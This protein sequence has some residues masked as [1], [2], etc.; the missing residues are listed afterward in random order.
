MR[1]T[2][3]ARA[4]YTHLHTLGTCAL[5]THTLVLGCF[6]SAQPTHALQHSLAHARLAL[7]HM[8]W[9]HTAEL[10]R[11]TRADVNKYKQLHS[12]QR[13]TIGIQH[14]SR[15]ADSPD[16]VSC[17]R[18]PSHTHCVC[19]LS[20][21]CRTWRSAPERWGGGTGQCCAAAHTTHNHLML[22]LDGSNCWRTRQ[23]AGTLSPQAMCNTAGGCSNAW[24]CWRGCSVSGSCVSVLSRLWSWLAALVLPC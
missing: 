24:K 8:A 3:A 9:L 21:A 13:H 11:C 14:A 15:Q 22:S 19:G 16:N 5:G 18:Q 12:C 20:R 17:D 6:H 4:W 10:Y 2:F 7:A 1:G 23:H